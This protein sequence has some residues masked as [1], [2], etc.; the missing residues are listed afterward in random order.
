MAE[1]MRRN[2]L[3]LPAL[4]LVIGVAAGCAS[5]G[6]V[7]RVKE[8]AAQAQSAAQQAQQTAQE[9]QSTADEASTVAD[10]AAET[11][12]EALRVSD[13]A[14]TCCVETNEKIDRMFKRS[15]AK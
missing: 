3:T 5:M 10:Q 8:M 12:N 4:G 14:N 13:E 6:E 15:M 11:A 2:L 7:E 1:N 9:A